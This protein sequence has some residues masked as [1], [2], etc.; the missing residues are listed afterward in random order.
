MMWVGFTASVNIAAVPV[1]PAGGHFPPP[2]AALRDPLRA[3]GEQPRDHHHRRNRHA[4]RL[5]RTRT[6]R[7]LLPVAVRR[8][9]F[10][11][12]LSVETHF[13]RSRAPGLARHGIISTPPRAP[14]RF[15]GWRP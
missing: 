6:L 12:A 3:P 5:H 9:S 13:S 1:L 14:W 7:A 11:N 4:A 2:Q 8:I 10:G 15:L